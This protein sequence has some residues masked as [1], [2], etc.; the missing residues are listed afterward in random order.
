MVVSEEV[1][2]YGVVEGYVNYR[3]FGYVFLVEFSR[4]VVSCTRKWSFVAREVE[5]I[6]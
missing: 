5:V 3:A 6:Y 1:F 2:D 4:F